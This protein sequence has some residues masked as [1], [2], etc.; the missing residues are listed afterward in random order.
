MRTA[1]C[2]DVEE[3]FCYFLQQCF[4]LNPGH[5]QFDWNDHAVALQ[6]SIYRLEPRRAPPEDIVLQMAYITH[7]DLMSCRMNGDGGG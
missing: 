1:A 7:R 3:T 4:T 2:K 6:V 5:R